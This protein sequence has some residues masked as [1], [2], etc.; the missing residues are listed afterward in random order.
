MERVVSALPLPLRRLADGL[1]NGR[2]EK[3]RSGRNA[4]LAFSIRVVSAAIAFAAQILLARWMGA[5]EFGVFT[6]VWVWVTIIGTLATLGFATSVIR[7]LP[8]YRASGRLE[9]F[10][11]YLRFGQAISFGAGAVAMFIGFALL[12][13]WGGRLETFYL[14]PMAFALL[15]LPAYALTDFLDG[16]GRSQGWI[17]LALAPPY[18]LRPLLL[19]AFIGAAIFVSGRENTAQTAVTA[20]LAATWATA[21]IQYF[22]QKQRFGRETFEGGHGFDAGL[23][24]KASLPLL[25][26]DGFA[27][28][29]LN[30]DIVILELFVPPEEIGKYFAAVR[31]ISLVSFIHFSVAAVAMPRFAS[32]AASGRRNEVL[33]FLKTMQIWTFLPSALAGA[34]L[35]ALGKPLLGLFGPE[36][37]AAYPVMIILLAG[38][39]MRAL[40]GP[41]QSLLIV[42]GHQGVAAVILGITVFIN[43]GMNLLLIPRYGL[44]GAA[45]A[46]AIAFAFESIA[47]M[48]M[49]RRCYARDQFDDRPRHAA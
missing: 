41:A 18:I 8:A 24:I 10:R 49:A 27:L 34:A 47:T 6:Y 5:M 35:I 29:M 20:A 7:F 38:I 40:A 13:I 16:T 36:F 22:L 21:A 4:I 26:L 14:A 17:D 31:T 46:T 33:P 39:L 19:F 37:V 48:I 9:L 23:W 3:A 15:C 2:G 45:A 1:L 12:A 43:A 28:L 30:L 25:L 11:G 44:P 42:T 32:L